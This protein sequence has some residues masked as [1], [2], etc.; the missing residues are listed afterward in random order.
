M[1]ENS[2]IEWTDHTFNPW[3]GCTEVSPGCAHCYAKTLMDTRYG[4]VKWGKGQPRVRTSAEN[5]KHPLAWNRKAAEYNGKCPKCCCL[6][7]V[8]GGNLACPRSHL[9]CDGILVQPRPRVFCASLADWLDDEVPVEWLADLLQLIRD[10]PKLDW[11][12]LTKRPEN[13]H[14]RIAAAD[15]DSAARPGLW[16]FIKLWLGGHPPENVWIG[17]TVEDQTRAN[18][19]IPQL[20]QIP[21]KV[22]FLSCEPLVGPVDIAAI[23]TAS[24]VE[25]L[26]LVG[27]SARE[28][29]VHWVICGGESGPGA[30]P[31]HPDWV[32]SLRDQCQSA[33][34]PFLFKQWGE[35]LPFYD[36]DKDDPDWRNVPTE[37]ERVKRINLCG[38]QGFHGE[39]VVYLQRVGKTNAG[40][41]LDG[42]EWNEFPRVESEVAV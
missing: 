41:Q 39:R 42:R 19:R 10:T 36:R 1:A 11:L 4:R 5:W 17:T 33:G 14:K 2:K 13:W 15:Y 26:P 25:Y 32:R 20:L 31:M 18:E 37:T 7:E 6:S 23:R 12:L 28:P 3:Y 40:R 34:A 9:E 21:A 22:R 8:R 35:W 30:R 38:G 27:T 16:S 24:G 29:R